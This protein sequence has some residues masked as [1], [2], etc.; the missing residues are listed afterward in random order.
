[1]LY[2]MNVKRLKKKGAFVE[3]TENV[4]VMFLLHLHINCVMFVSGWLVDETHVH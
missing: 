3:W 4:L 1:M 2:N